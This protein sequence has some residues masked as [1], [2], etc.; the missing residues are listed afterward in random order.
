[1]LKVC[2]RVGE[3]GSEG[4]GCDEERTRGHVGEGLSEP[5]LARRETGAPVVG[6]GVERLVE[7]EEVERERALEEEP[8][9]STR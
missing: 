8:G 5:W 1:M 9:S 6:G 2:R 4:E 7:E 3:E